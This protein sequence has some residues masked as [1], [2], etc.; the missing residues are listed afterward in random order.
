MNCD[1]AIACGLDALQDSIAPERDAELGAHLGGCARCRAELESLAQAW[2]ALG[3]GAVAVPHE[4]L[5][6]RFHATLAAEEERAR[7][8]RLERWLEAWWP[9]RRALQAA[10]AIALALF[11]IALGRSWP[12]TSE[13]DV[14]AL[15]DEVRA[16]GLALLDHQSA[17]ERLLGIEGA[18]RASAS[19]EVV[20]ALL[21][22]VA[23]D[24]N[25]N[26]RLAAINALRP[27]VGRAEVADGLAAALGRQ[28]SPLLQVAL[29]DALLA[30]GSARGI[31]AVRALLASDSLEPTVRDYVETA[32]RDAGAGPAP[33][34]I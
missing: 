32:L 31:S 15:R 29:T 17:A 9:E 1:D 10:V 8:P 22:R 2:R 30:T 24:P 27:Q 25:V 3:T 19:R 33:S 21:A 20:D 34:D 14:A 11:G 28:E 7:G 18:Q 26:V 16:L 12:T 6:A 13:H 5:R 4:R 23:F